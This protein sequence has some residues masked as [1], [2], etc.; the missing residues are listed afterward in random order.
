MKQHEGLLLALRPP[1]WY[2]RPARC[3]WRRRCCRC[4]RRLRSRDAGAQ[5]TKQAEVEEGRQRVRQEAAAAGRADE[6][7]GDEQEIG[8]DGRRKARQKR[9]GAGGRQHA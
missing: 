2:V 5:H 9:Y 1:C 4:R 6:T 7:A 8:R 3:T